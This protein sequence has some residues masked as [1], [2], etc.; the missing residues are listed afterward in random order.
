LRPGSRQPAEIGSSLRIGT[1]PDVVYLDGMTHIKNFE[2]RPWPRWRF[3][4]DDNLAIEQE[5][6]VPY[7]QSAL[8]LIWRLAGDPGNKA[9]L[10]VRPFLSGRDF[11]GMHHENNSFRFQPDLRGDRVRWK[12]YNDIPAVVAAIPL[13]RRFAR[14]PRAGTQRR[15]ARPS[16][17]RALLLVN[18]T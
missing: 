13:M 17:L 15:S 8:V 10:T 1:P 9:E 12:P 16:S 4:L 18:I 11:H 5:L 2:L 6:F 3:K 14:P 7:G